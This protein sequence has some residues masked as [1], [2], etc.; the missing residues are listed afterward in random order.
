[1]VDL[2]G[3]YLKI[4]NEINLSIQSVI[5]SS[6]FIQGPSVSEFKISLQNFLNIKQF[7]KY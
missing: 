3:Q 4:Q 7:F 1:M 5:N 6:S 2:Y